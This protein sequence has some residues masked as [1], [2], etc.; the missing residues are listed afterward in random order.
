MW[1]ENQKMPWK[2]EISTLPLCFANTLDLPIQSFHPCS[3]SES[4]QATGHTCSASLSGLACAPASLPLV[5]IPS[6][7]LTPSHKGSSS[8][9]GT[10]GHS[11][12]RTEACKCPRGLWRSLQRWGVCVPPDTAPHLSTLRSL[13]SRAHL[14]GVHHIWGWVLDYWPCLETVIPF[15]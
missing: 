4:H 2:V 9:L 11:W 7:C 15:L 13:I 10:L 8:L 5:C 12:L 6:F 3:H 1:G 14:K